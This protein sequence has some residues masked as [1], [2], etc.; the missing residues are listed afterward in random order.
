MSMSAKPNRSESTGPQSIPTLAKETRQSAMGNTTREQD[1]RRRAYEIYLERG[2]EPGD[3][4]DDW[5]KAERELA[6][7]AFSHAE[8]S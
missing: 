5:L 3:E 6:G 1:I 8:A 4:L 7:A 2:Q